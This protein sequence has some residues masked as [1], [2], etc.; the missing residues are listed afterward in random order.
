[1]APRVMP[2]HR[3]IVTNKVVVEQLYIPRRRLRESINDL[4]DR[5]T[6]ACSDYQRLVIIRRSDEL[7][8]KTSQLG[9]DKVVAVGRALHET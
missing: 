2:S 6:I 7:P 8:I 1:M 4:F 9:A 5:D 3:L